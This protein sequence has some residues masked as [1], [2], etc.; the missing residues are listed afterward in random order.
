MFPQ[1]KR[2]ETKFILDSFL[3]GILPSEFQ[4]DNSTVIKRTPTKIYLKSKYIKFDNLYSLFI[5]ACVM[6]NYFLF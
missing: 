1:D 4:E 3:K 2:L 6:L 5:L